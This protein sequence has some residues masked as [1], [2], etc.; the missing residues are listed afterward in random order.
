[1]AKNF[2]RWATWTAHVRTHK[3]ETPCSCAVLVRR[4]TIKE[5]HW[6][7]AGVNT[8]E[9]DVLHEDGEVKSHPMWPLQ[10]QCKTLLSILCRMIEEFHWR[11]TKLKPDV[12]LS[13]K[14]KKTTTTTYFYMGGAAPP[15]HPVLP[16][17]L[18][19]EQT[20]CNR[21]IIWMTLP[22]WVPCLQRHIQ[23]GGVGGG[24]QEPCTPMHV[25]CKGA[26]GGLLLL[27][28]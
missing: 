23:G 4:N 8:A 21:N 27:N 15:T 24:Q 12:P 7:D 11:W 26:F 9:R 16:T 3:W 2:T 14:F 17:L 19:C 1:M 6:T 18:S 10:A 5:G 25:L 22:I 13:W 20:V 28:V